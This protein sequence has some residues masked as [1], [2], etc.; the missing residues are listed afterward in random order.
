ME[1]DAPLSLPELMSYVNNMIAFMRDG[2]ESVLESM[3]A[4]L[5]RNKD[6]T[7]SRTE[8]KTVMMSVS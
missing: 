7:V 2:D 5:D 1:E 4:T 3:F 6:G 8:L